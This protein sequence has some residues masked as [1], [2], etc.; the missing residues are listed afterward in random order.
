MLSAK[1]NRSFYFYYHNP[2]G[3]FFL[4]QMR[5]FD[6]NFKPYWDYKVK[7]ERRNKMNSGLS[8]KNTSSCKWPIYHQT[9]KSM[10]I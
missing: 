4:V 6:I 2:S 3:F 9:Q 10:N 5:V 7:Q 1:Y 8:S